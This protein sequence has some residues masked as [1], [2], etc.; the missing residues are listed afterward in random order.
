MTN[1][2]ENDQ[3]SV[4]K[5]VLDNLPRHKQF[6]LSTVDTDG[7]PWVVCVNL[8]FDDSVNF[9]WLSQKNTEHSK[10][11]ITRSKVAICVF[12][13]IEGVG[14]FGYYCLA[15]AHEVKDEVELGKLLEIRFGQKGRPVPS[16]DSFL[17][18]SPVRIYYGEV[19]AAW[20][21]DDRHLK[22]PVNLDLLKKLNS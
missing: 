3:Q 1:Y 16:L 19:H 6:A 11:I 10:N 17:S 9:I 12:S 14:E 21:N 5:F 22:M 7:D 4:A 2:D 18:S 13:E 15:S 8:S 20:V